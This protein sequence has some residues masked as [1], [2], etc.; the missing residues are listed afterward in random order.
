MRLQNCLGFL[1]TP[2]RCRGMRR[3]KQGYT[4]VETII[5]L[6]L[7]GI[8]LVGAV[9]ATINHAAYVK[10]TTHRIIAQ[11][12]AQGEIGKLRVLG[13]GQVLNMVGQSTTTVVIDEGDPERTSDSV[14]GQMIRTVQTRDLDGNGTTDVLYLQIAI[15]WNQFGRTHEQRSVSLLTR[16][17][18]S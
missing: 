6:L 1:R 12:I 15:R 2:N 11:G 14:V 4:I 9:T 3:Q 10:S 16:R 5:A 18:F 13:Y 7:I 17:N 8:S